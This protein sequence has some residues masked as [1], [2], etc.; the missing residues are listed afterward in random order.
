MLTKE[1]DYGKVDEVIQL[2]AVQTRAVTQAKAMI[3]NHATED[4]A[5]TTSLARGDTLFEDLDMQLLWDRAVAADL[6]YRVV[7]Y[8]VTRGDRSLPTNVDR[9]IQMPDCSFDERGIVCY[10]DIVWVPNH[11]PLCTSL[12]QHTHDSHITGHPGWDATLAILSRNF[13]WPQQYLSVR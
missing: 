2:S 12:I 3:Q 13:F 9:V 4:Y 11:E 8:V 6:V 1:T 7:H 5:T 10:R